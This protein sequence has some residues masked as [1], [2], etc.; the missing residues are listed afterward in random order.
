[1][2]TSPMPHKKGM[3][4]EELAERREILVLKG[5]LEAVEALDRGYAEGGYSRAMRLVSETLAARSQRAYV[6]SWEI[7]TW[8]ALAGE[9]DL[10]LDWLEKAYDDRGGQMGFI[11]VDPDWDVL[12]DD[13]RF[14]ELLR[15]MNLPG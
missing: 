4:E 10:A 8:Y 13:P 6:P 7:A 5:D 1:M 11:N 2:G 9:N 14:Q 15:R 12:R 3:H